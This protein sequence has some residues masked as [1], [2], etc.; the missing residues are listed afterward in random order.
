VKHKVLWCLFVLGV[1]LFIFRFSSSDHPTHVANY[2]SPTPAP[3]KSGSPTPV[4]LET[5]LQG[6]RNENASPESKKTLTLEAESPTLDLVR[7][8]AEQN[9]H[10]TPP[11]ILK[12]AADLG[13]KMQVARQSENEARKFYPELSNC[14]RDVPA[15]SYASTPQT[16]CFT[17][18][19]ELAKQ[20]PSLARNLDGLKQDLDPDTLKRFNQF[21]KVMEKPDGT[22]TQ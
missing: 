16:L 5:P 19:V 2:A 9:P 22:H 1:V 21:E 17:D 11:S 8:E 12:F 10:E 14:A 4:I 20:Y 13:E 6:A 3:T 15:G 7:K 18:A